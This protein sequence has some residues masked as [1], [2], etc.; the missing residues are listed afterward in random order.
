MQVKQAAN[1]KMV[2]DFQHYHFQF[3]QLLTIL[4]ANGFS[5]L[6]VKMDILHKNTSNIDEVITMANWQKT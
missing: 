2:L 5:E 6:D 4:V 3:Q 1:F